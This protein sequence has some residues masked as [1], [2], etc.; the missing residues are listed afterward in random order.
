MSPRRS[1]RARAT[2][3]P[4]VAPHHTNS[5]TS[6]NSFNRAERSTR[7]HNKNQSPPTTSS[8]QRSQSL[9]DADDT[10]K[11]DLPQTRQRRS[12]QRGRDEDIQ[13]ALKP[14]GR[15][16]DDDDVEA[17]EV[18]RCICGH[19]DYPGP[20]LT[21]HGDIKPG[22]KDEGVTGT[23]VP[24]DDLGSFF[25]QCD[26]CKVWQHGGCVG[27]MDEALLDSMDYFCEQCRKDL[28]KVLAAANG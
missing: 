7:S 17:E 22:V 27:I 16:E 2:Q 4:P 20:P 14:S 24:L 15:V 28:H 5:S 13:D 11:T 18:T 8:T 26:N 21:G 19:Q 6:S 12:Q 23:D 25:I 10:T 1:S 9:D 3:P